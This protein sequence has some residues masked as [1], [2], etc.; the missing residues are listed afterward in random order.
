MDS[1]LVE[2]GTEEIPAG[3]IQ[4][5]LNAFSSLLTQRLR[6]ARIEHGEARV[7]G[8]PRRLAVE[9][10]QVAKRQ[11]SLTEEVIGPPQRVGYDE[12]GRPTMAAEKFAE[13]IGISV[14]D[15]R[16]KETEKGA[17]LCAIKAEKGLTTKALLRVILPEVILSLSFPK[18][19]RWGDFDIH[20]AR[21]IHSVAALL[22]KN[23]ISFA[24]GNIRSGRYVSGHRFMSP[25]RIKIVEP[26][27]YVERLRTANVFVDMEERKKIIEKDIS[28]AAR[29]L[30]GRVLP[31]NELVDI[32]NNLVEYP[33]VAAGKFDGKF[34]ELPREVLITAMREHQ[35]YFAVI[36]ENDDLMPCFIAVNNTLANDMALV[37]K[38][39][40]RVLRARLEDARFFYK[41]D[42]DESLE[43][44]LEKLKGVLFQASLGSVYEKVMRIRE[45]AVFLAEAVEKNSGALKQQVSEAAGLCKADLVSQVVVEFPKLQGVMGR[46]YALA[47][48]VPE[49]VAVAIEEHYRPAYSGG[50]L[51]ETI[52]GAILAIADKMDS[53]CGCFSVGLI[54]TGV[55]DPY[56]LRRQG[57]GIVQIMLEKEFSFSLNG[58]IEKNLKLFGERNGQKIQETADKVR[59]FLKNR[60]AYLLAEDGYSKDAIAAVVDVS[61]DHVPDV[62]KRVRALET[63]KSEPDFEPLAVAFKRVVNIIKK[64]ARFQAGDI[65]ENLFQHESESV[66]YEAFKVVKK[67]VADDLEKGLFDRALHDIASLRNPVDAFFEGVMVMAEDADLRQNR[68]NLLSHVSGLFE[69]F[70]DFSKIST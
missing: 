13:K 51:P 29:N 14:N 26:A 16:I 15:L 33:A 22:G 35:K 60:M 20:F 38:G 12:T 66:L 31:D 52:P 30:G 65:N 9:V 28:K 21:P 64:A 17:Y 7:Y 55:S 18:T 62:W 4:P 2:I 5:A 1:L 39:H 58:L 59:G 10:E 48:G 45:I 46:H 36:D 43:S 57:I 32:V 54:P 23:V 44:R 34:L 6:E 56:A 47:S 68:L 63:L 8:T 42:L 19:M 24:V 41:S 3:Y 53:I 11:E 37:A 27:D 70:A 40:E 69:V 67:K 49:P 25:G 61:V 50:P